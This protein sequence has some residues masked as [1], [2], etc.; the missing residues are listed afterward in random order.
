MS[1]QLYMYETEY[2]KKIQVMSLQQKKLFFKNVE[3]FKKIM[4]KNEVVKNYKNSKCIKNYTYKNIFVKE[5]EKEFVIFL[6]K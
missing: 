3:I 6:K 1:L 4:N 5:D 2:V